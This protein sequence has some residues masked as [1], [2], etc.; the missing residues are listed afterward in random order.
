MGVHAENQAPAVVP[1]DSGITI[2]RDM[3]LLAQQSTHSIRDPQLPG[4]GSGMANDAGLLRPLAG[5]S[6]HCLCHFTR[7]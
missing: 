3:R 7:L 6:D 4:A 1:P 2:W 5:I